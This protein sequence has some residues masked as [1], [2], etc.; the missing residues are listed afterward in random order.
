[1]LVTQAYSYGVAF[2]QIE[3]EVDT[4]TR[5]VLAK[6]ARIVPTWADVP[7]GRPGD[8]EA[9]KL[10]EAAQSLVAARVTQVVGV[11]QQT[12]GRTVSAAGESALGDLVADAQREATQADIALMNP[13][14]LRSDLAAG[15]VTWG[16]ILTLHPFANHL[17]TLEMT[18]QQLLGLLE[19]QWPREPGDSTRILKTSGLFYSWDPTKPL[20]SHVQIACD[21]ARRPLDPDRRYRVTVS[22]FLAAGGDKFALL[23]TL[24]PGEVGPLDSEALKQYLQRHNPTGPPSEPRLSRVDLAELSV[25]RAP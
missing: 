3:L 9:R 25:C 6:S 23:A 10:A 2:A 15:P 16:E 20:G 8:E 19:Q 4:K 24:G 5:D 18:G 1:V 7:P 13:G 22:D 21:S 17:V 11:L 14:G 12:M